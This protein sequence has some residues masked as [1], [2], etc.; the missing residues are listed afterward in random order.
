MP[1]NQAT[2]KHLLSFMSKM[3]SAGLHPFVMDTFAYYYKKIVSGETGRISDRDIR[4][5][6]SNE[7]QDATRMR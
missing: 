7:V 5:I 2:S 6:A 1:E 3:E 4:P